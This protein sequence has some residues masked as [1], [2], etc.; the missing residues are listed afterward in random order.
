MISRLNRLGGF[1]SRFLTQT[2]AI[3]AERL[4]STN[5]FRVVLAIPQTR[6]YSQEI[7]L[8]ARA[9]SRSRLTPFLTLLLVAGIGATAYGVYDIYGV[10]TL[11]PIEVRKDLRAGVSA[12][13]KEDFEL[14]EQ[15]L[16]RAWE[17]S[18][19]L[20]LDAF[21]AQPHLKTSGIAVCLAGVLESNGKVDKAYDV[22]VE[23]LSQL[24]EVGTKELLSGPENLR[25]VAISYKL[26]E[27]AA[28]LQ[29]P[30][31]EEQHLVW[32]V[33]ALLKSILPTRGPNTGEHHSQAS[34]S[35]ALAITTELSLPDWATNTDIAAPFEALGTYYAHAGKLDYAISLY[36]Q[37][38][39]VLIPPPPEQSSV[40]DRC[41]GAQL[42]TNL[43]E[44]IVRSQ[45]SLETK[46]LDQAEAWARK[47]L[48]ITVHTKESTSTVNPTCE[49]AFAVALFNLAA[50]RKMA[51]DKEEAKQFFLLS[52]KQSRV[53]G[54]QAGIDHAEAALRELD[55]QATGA[56]N[57]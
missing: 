17:T 7:P 57:P 22:Y 3:K 4:K 15:Y 37:A 6:P 51:G 28:L 48:D 34:D 8:A 25:A 26:G 47:A 36:L 21:G 40:E 31:E 44:I 50:I 19:T 10:M 41:R 38:I 11:W 46:T 20:P 1:K 9:S 14:S 53:I 13:H 16:R 29:K 24:Q 18:K 35:D 54:M 27:L 30:E 32:A 43:S 39:S 2:H 49:V 55:T 12:K 42:M 33:E 45:H 56:S 23:A 52:L 5:I